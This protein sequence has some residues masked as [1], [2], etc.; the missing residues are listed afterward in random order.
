MNAVRTIRCI[1]WALLFGV[2]ACADSFSLE[3]ARR[4]GQFTHTA[5]GEKEGA[6]S[7]IFAITQTPDG[8]LWLASLHGLFRFD[9]V[10]FEHYP[11]PAGPAIPP[12]RAFSLLS[13][14]NGD[15]WIGFAGRISLLKNGQVRNYTDKDGVPIANITSL[16]RDRQGTIWAG[17]GAGLVRLEGDRWK[18]VGSAWGFA[19]KSVMALMVDSQGT[20][21]V[22]TESTIVFL[23][24]GTGAFQSTSVRVGDVPQLLEAPNG[25]LWMAE[26]SRSVRPIP[27]GVKLPPLDTAEI[28]VGSQGILFARAGDLWITTVGN[29]IRRV[30]VPELLRAKAG[31]HDPAVESFTTKEGLSD[32]YCMSVFQDHDS[33]IWIG[34]LS[35]LDR[36]RPSAVV[37]V[38]LPVSSPYPLLAPG[39]SGDIW[40]FIGEHIFHIDDSSVH[41]IKNP[42]DPAVL[43]TYVGAYQES[44]RATWLISMQPALVR[45]ENGRFSRFPPPKELPKPFIHYLGITEDGSG[46]LWMA[47]DHLG[48]FRRDKGTW[49]R[50][51]APFELSKSSV[52][53]AFKD[54]LGR[55]WFGYADGSIIYLDGGKIRSLTTRQ[56]SPVRG[57]SVISAR[58]QHV[59]VGGYSRLAF[60]DGDKFHIAVPAD[61]PA[62][63]GVFGILELADGNLWLCE[64]RG[65]IHIDASE[66]RKFLK[67]PSYRV[68]YEIF[69]SRDGL[70]GK[71]QGARN[72]EQTLVEGTDG[73]IWVGTDHGIAWV[74]P[75]TVPAQV[76]LQISI[77]SI[78]SAD[79]PFAIQ[80]GLT[81]PPRSEDVHIDYT[82]MNLSV[83]ERVRYRYK[84]DGVDKDW[85]SPGGRREAF[86]TNLGPGRYRFH[87]NARNEGGE[88]NPEEAVLD[89]RIAPAWFQTVWFRVFCVCDFLFLLWMLYQLRLRQLKRQFSRT[90]EARVSERTRI[91]R[92]LHD[93]LLQS[94]S[95]LLL[96][97]QSASSLIAAHPNEAR[98]RVDSAIEQASDA[99]AEGRDAVHQLR[100]GE[101]MTS[102][103]AQSIKNF[104]AEIMEEPGGENA[105]QFRILTEGTPRDP[106]PMVRDEVFRIAAEA[107][108][109]AVRHAAAQNIEVEIRYDE[110]QLRLRIRDDGKGVDPQVLEPGHAPGHWGLRGMRERAKLMGGNLEVWSEPGSGTEVELTIPGANAW[111]RSAS[112]WSILPR[113]R[114]S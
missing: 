37:P 84:L 86:Y 75:A 50:F 19:G 34:S 68:R 96:R 33:N 73:R 13:L 77:R 18:E 2:A 61:R 6:P 80:T 31:R 23:P 102:D 15:L 3:T 88:W 103:L 45:L 100:S 94:F 114:R 49:S 65:V 47:A 62:F 7:V 113:N 70:P 1:A 14:P 91:A 53:A 43:S 101:L 67:S 9:G 99:I 8:Y 112:R 57:V 28:P 105:P 36:F 48:L 104:G 38:A 69:D 58:N 4:L 11:L 95:A 56:T 83:P 27:L 108:R 72:S 20:L 60:F 87:M 59:W 25:K 32:N 71:F 107:L 40:A 51:G 78:S 90:L 66:V 5:W 110:Q 21:W 55:A 16:A 85:Q 22:A 93:T 106:D 89:F 52:T 92:D 12:E 54:D 42:D 74:A 63:E 26:T 29:G 82:A 79:R 39:G 44:G 81:L 64:Q 98:Q 97:L 24:Q 30:P 10:T 76:P 17:S 41:E 46:A 35:G 111:A 109:N